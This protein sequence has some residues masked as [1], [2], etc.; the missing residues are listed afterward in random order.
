M[1]K[2]KLDPEHGPVVHAE[3]DEVIDEFGFVAAMLRIDANAVRFNWMMQ[4]FTSPVKMS[5]E[6][7]AEI[8]R[9]LRFHADKL[10]SRETDKKMEALW[11]QMR[12]VTPEIGQ[13]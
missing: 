13:A 8:V 11:K 3:V 10:E 4:V 1:S 7:R 5:D 12:H 6:I 9:V 2:T